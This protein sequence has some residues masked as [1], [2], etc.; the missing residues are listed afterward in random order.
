MIDI[1][2]IKA[3]FDK[4]VIENIDKENAHKIIEFL[5]KEKCIFIDEIISDYLDLFTFEYGEFSNKYKR[6]N[7]KYNGKFLE[8]A[9]KDMNLLEEFYIENDNTKM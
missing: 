6:L 5:I 4:K 1:N 2:E 8:K 9:S 3:K 7:N